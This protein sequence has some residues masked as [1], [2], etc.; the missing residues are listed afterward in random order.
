[1]IDDPE[2][3]KLYLVL[4][5]LDQG[6]VMG[7]EA[8][9]LSEAAAR[10]ALLETCA[11]LAHLHA[12]G[13]VHGDLKPGNLLRGADGRV[14]I[15]DFG[16]ASVPPG[17]VDAPI[18]RSPGTPAFTAPECCAGGAYSGR[19]AD[20]WA[21]G[22]TL[23]M[24]LVGRPPFPGHNLLDTY[25]SIQFRELARGTTHTQR[26]APRAAPAA[27]AVRARGAGGAGG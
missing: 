14:R 11:G 17:G 1:M 16:T 24:L 8:P 13:V 19:R 15:V 7:D 12:Q 26:N 5:L 4:E 18:T 3:D 9:P 22:A 20:L 21:L 27:W 23:Y 25:E 10:A 2:E 6:P